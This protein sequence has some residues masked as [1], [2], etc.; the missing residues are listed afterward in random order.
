MKKEKSYL[1][2]VAFEAKKRKK[3]I[4]HINYKKKTKRIKEERRRKHT[5]A[6]RIR[7]GDED[8]REE[9]E[10]NIDVFYI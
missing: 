2:V 1:N 9:K 4:K 10:I 8:R 7:D 6:W 3:F 5:R